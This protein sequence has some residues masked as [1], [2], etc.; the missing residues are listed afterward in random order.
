MARSNVWIS[1]AGALAILAGTA[2][3]ADAP[4]LKTTATGT[5]TIQAI[6]VIRFGPE[7]IRLI[8]D[9]KGSQ[10]L[11][12]ATGDTTKKATLKDPIEKID[13]KIAGRLGT[14]ANGIEIVG[15]AV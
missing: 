8:G 15:L 13:E 12:I 11:A 7:G 9:G 1:A 10:V 5:P 3:A 6:E 4:A 14:T 2:A